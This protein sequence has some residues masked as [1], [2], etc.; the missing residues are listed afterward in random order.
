[1]SFVTLVCIKAVVWQPLEK[2]PK[3]ATQR[4]PLMM[5]DLHPDN[6]FYK[7]AWNVTE[8]AKFREEL[9]V[10]LPQTFME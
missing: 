2:F 6:F 9:Q 10:L 7:D 3:V 4:P 8:T 1:M 5:S